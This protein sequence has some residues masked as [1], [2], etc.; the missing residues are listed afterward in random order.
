MFHHLFLSI[1]IFTL[2]SV[3]GYLDIV[4]EPQQHVRTKELKNNNEH[5]FNIYFNY[6]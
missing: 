5:T 3:F 4:H 6:M 2:T 1:S